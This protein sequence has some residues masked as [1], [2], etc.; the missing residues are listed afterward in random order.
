MN[1]EDKSGK[2]LKRFG[3]DKKS[4]LKRA[5]KAE[6][7]TL[8]H[9]RKFITRRLDNVQ[10]VRRHVIVWLGGIALLI[11]AVG[12]QLIWFLGS[13]MH[14]VESDGGTYAEATIGPIQTLNPLYASSSSEIT[15]T[16]LLFSSLFA[17][18]TSGHLNTDT[19]KSITLSQDSMSYIVELQP[20]IKWHDGKSL[21]VKDVAYTINL[22]K[23]PDARSPLRIQWQDVQVNILSDTTI[24]FRLPS[25]YAP[26]PHALTFPILPEHVLKDVKP[27]ALREN[28]FSV[29]PVGSGPFQLKLLQ[30]VG[31]R[32]IANL[33]AYKD[34]FKGAPKLSRFEIHAFNN[35]EDILRALRASQ[36]GAAADLSDVSSVA[37]MENYKVDYHEVSN[38]VYAFLNT[39]QPIL[40]DVAVRRA[41]QQSLDIAAIHKTLGDKY[42]SLDLPFVTGQIEVADMPQVKPRNMIEAARL[43]D[44]AGWKLNGA[45]RQKEAVKLELR[46]VAIK[47]PQYEKIVSQMKKDWSALG[48]TVTS[49]LIDPSDRSQDFTQN[50]LQPRAYDVL[51]HELSI[52]ADPD[53]YAFWHSS[54]VGRGGLN[55]SVYT[56]Q[57]A[58]DALTSARDRREPNLRAL[59]YKAFAKQWLDDAPAIG[60]YQSRLQYVSSKQTHSIDDT[61]RLISP[62]DRFANVI[63]WT[64][65][66]TSV[67]KTP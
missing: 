51:I 49:A 39:S 10:E 46:V 56:S 53:V 8:R 16:R 61:Q 40:K 66:Q 17:Y 54:Q 21:T 23:N 27:S 22:M 20:N 13:Y 25:V 48:V 59:K 58:D 31:D 44:E 9:A 62:Y 50:V 60:L 11:L 55:L 45:I 1:E 29:A 65:D 19:A 34:Y 6:S 3:F 33:T 30:A 38:G 5:R 2:G 57:L 47:S 35:Q 52:G 41:L 63:Y 32:R 4:A 7:A 12:L 14:T 26:F 24:Q 42:V 43:L 28:T 37:N 67:Y 36:V 64:A 18:D 15:A